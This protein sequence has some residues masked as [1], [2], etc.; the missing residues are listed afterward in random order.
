VAVFLASNATSS[1]GALPLRA[2]AMVTARNAASSYG[3]LP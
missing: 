3:A 2:V 1:N